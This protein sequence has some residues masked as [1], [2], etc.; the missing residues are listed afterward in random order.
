MINVTR[1]NNARIVINADMIQS[2][3]AAPDTIITFTNNDRLMVR[4]A[5]EEI[6]DK[7]MAYRKSVNNSMPVAPQP[8]QV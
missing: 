1:L 6:S 8:L 5:V 2:L 7:I 4:E 3:K